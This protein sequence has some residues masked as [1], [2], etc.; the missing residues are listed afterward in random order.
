MLGQ[1]NIRILYVV[2]A[3]K[4]F[5]LLHGFNKKKQ[6]TDKREIDTAVARLREY[7]SRSK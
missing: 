3:G 1:D 2:T 5:L 6:K 7:N 4:T